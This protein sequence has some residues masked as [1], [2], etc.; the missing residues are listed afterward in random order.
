MLDIRYHACSRGTLR[1]NLCVRETV[2]FKAVVNPNPEI[3]SSGRVHNMVQCTVLLDMT[4]GSGFAFTT[5]KKIR[6]SECCLLIEA[7]I[8]TYIKEMLPFILMLAI[9]SFQICM[10]K[11]Y[12]MFCDLKWDISLLP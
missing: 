2:N 4:P 6:F 10:Q 11:G 9:N 7:K 1:F 8:T 12:H 3:R 5:R